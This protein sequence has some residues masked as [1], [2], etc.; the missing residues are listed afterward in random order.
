[1]H[2]FCILFG[3]ARCTVQVYQ[4]LSVDRANPVG[5]FFRC[6]KSG[7]REPCW[8]CTLYRLKVI[9]VWKSI[10]QQQTGYGVSGVKKPFKVFSTTLQIGFTGSYF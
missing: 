6:G 1:V 8:A 2:D 4:L 5:S 9:I 10:F 3:A 7:I